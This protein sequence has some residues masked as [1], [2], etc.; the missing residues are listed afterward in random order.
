M[1][2]GT[3][4]ADV[5]DPRFQEIFDDDYP[6]LAGQADQFYKEGTEKL[7]TERWSQ[8]GALTEMSDFT[9]TVPYPDISQGYDTTATGLEFAQGIQVERRLIEFDQHDVIMDKPK[10]L[11]DS[12]ALLRK[13]HRVRPFVNAF[14][15]DTKFYNNTEGVAWCSNSH[16]TTS[17]AS[18]AAGFDNLVLTG[19]SATAVSAL[20]LQMIKHRNDQGQEIGIMPDTLYIPSDLEERAYEIV[21][22]SGKVDEA[23]NNASF[24][25]GQY[26]V[27]G[28][29]MLST[30][31]STVDWFMIDSNLIK[32]W[33][34]IWLDKI[35]GE[36]GMVED[37]DTLV[38][39]WRVYC[40]WT[41]A[42]RDW[43]AISGADVS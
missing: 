21:A 13:V 36:F 20:R 32:R 42:V 17:G 41:Q 6:G 34:L 18:T 39:K 14:S 11:A 7:E 22:S 43:R 38:G 9:G 5:Y 10:S 19:I 2:R 40:L 3:N 30:R 29:L 16:T 8:L 12:V 35:K 4:F 31:G 28:D 33:G 37:F 15:V 24:N 27:V 25:Y 1:L 26:K 23:T